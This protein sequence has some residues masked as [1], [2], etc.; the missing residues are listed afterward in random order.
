[1]QRQ[2]FLES[3]T[4]KNKMI[5]YQLLEQSLSGLR[6]H[7]PRN[8]VKARRP[9]SCVPASIRSEGYP[10]RHQLRSLHGASERFLLAAS[11]YTFG[12]VCQGQAAPC[13]TRET[14]VL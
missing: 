4:A 6:L 8:T 7:C 9:K 14:L 12:M 13:I 1:M 11:R 2:V 10:F 3:W 5:F